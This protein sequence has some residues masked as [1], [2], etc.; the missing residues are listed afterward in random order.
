MSKFS[1]T[2][3]LLIFGLGIGLFWLWDNNSTRLQNRERAA[4]V[5]DL[6]DYAARAYADWLPPHISRQFSAGPLPGQITV[7]D[8]VGSFVV[9]ANTP[10]AI[11]CEPHAVFVQVG[12]HMLTPYITG[13]DGAPPLGVAPE[14]PAASRTAA[15]ACEVVKTHLSSIFIAP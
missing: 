3:K 13:M 7:K 15:A 9:S 6:P 1:T 2:Q 12:D 4:A 11:D 8:I 14:S 5:T 10:Y